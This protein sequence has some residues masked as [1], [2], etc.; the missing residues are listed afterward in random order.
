VAARRARELHQ[1]NA[2]RTSLREYARKSNAYFWYLL[3]HDRRKLAF[4]L[5]GAGMAPVGR[6]GRL[7]G[8]A[9]LR[10]SSR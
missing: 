10:G 2:V 3:L 7:A 1:Q 5:K 9:P 6:R 4:Q 8:V